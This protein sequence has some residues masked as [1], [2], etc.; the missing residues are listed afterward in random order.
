MWEIWV[1]W[2]LRV[3]AGK[4]CHLEAERLERAAG[5]DGLDLFN[6]QSNG[7]GLWLIQP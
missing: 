4:V 1:L 3:L 7:K 2:V 5:S 6:R